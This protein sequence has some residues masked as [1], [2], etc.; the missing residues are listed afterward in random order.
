MLTLTPTDMPNRADVLTS[1]DRAVCTVHCINMRTPEALTTLNIMD[2][3][4]WQVH[5]VKHVT[6]LREK[7]CCLHLQGKRYPTPFMHCTIR[8][9]TGHIAP[10]KATSPET[11]I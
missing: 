2:T 1:M 11:A 3:V 5:Y 10:S 9:T 7:T 6:T 8:L 4:F